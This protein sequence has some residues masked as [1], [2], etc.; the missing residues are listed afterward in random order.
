M[1]D[2]TLDDVHEYLQLWRDDENY[3]DFNLM[4]DKGLTLLAANHLV[5]AGAIDPAI[6]YEYAKPIEEYILQCVENY[7]EKE[8]TSDF[9]EFWIG[10][11]CW[12]GKSNE[13]YF[14]NKEIHFID[15]P[16]L[17]SWGFKKVS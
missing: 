7:T 12:V 6:C 9:E 10:T 4:L 13:H 5:E 1:K 3:T 17:K 15:D 2:F 16:E 14:I 8:K 11:V